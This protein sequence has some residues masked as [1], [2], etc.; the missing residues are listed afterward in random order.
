MS[1]GLFDDILRNKIAKA[2]TETHVKY[3]TSSLFPTLDTLKDI[4][5]STRDTSDNEYAIHVLDISKYDG[6]LEFRS[7]DG[8]IISNGGTRDANYGLYICQL[9][10]EQGYKSPIIN[11]AIDLGANPSAS[12]KNLTTK[13][14]TI[15]RF[16]GNAVCRPIIGKKCTSYISCGALRAFMDHQFIDDN[17][18]IY[19]LP[20][21]DICAITELH[22]STGGRL[23]KDV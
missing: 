13:E 6:K 9:D 11:G 23:L 21:S 1:N 15:I 17:N 19:G 18:A 7:K 5:I 14:I 10:K 12:I 4:F 16:L 20:M 2:G 8:L 3:P 22:L